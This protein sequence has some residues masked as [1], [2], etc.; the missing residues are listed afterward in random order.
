M[1]KEPVIA[2]SR[3]ESERAGTHLVLMF[4]GFSTDEQDLMGLVPAL[5][6]EGFTYASM[7][8]P[9]PSV[10]GQGHQWFALD[11]HLDYDVEA[12]RSTVS[13]VADWIAGNT[14]GFS[15]VTLLGFSQGMAVATS[16]AR[17]RP[18]LAAAVVG[19]SGFLVLDVP[20][21]F[22]DAALAARDPRLPLFYGRGQEDAVI[23]EESVA[24]VL[25]W[26]REHVDLTKVVYA[27]LGHGISN[28]EAGHVAEFLRHVAR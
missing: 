25:D 13:A 20:G 26:S 1:T 9:E 14:G 4:H 10:V 19:L 5:P 3:P 21:F 2:W 8:G 17:H 15:G 27:G 22:D 11:Q 6:A 12:V 23:S 28:Q 16:V 7:R 18:D 24:H